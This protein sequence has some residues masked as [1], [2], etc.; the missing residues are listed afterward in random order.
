MR[1]SG[2]Y[3]AL[4]I[5]GWS[6]YFILI[7][8][9]LTLADVLDTKQVLSFFFLSVYFLFTTHFLRLIVLKRQWLNV[10]VSNFIGKLTFTILVFS[11]FNFGFQ[12]LLSFIFGLLEFSRDFQP[13]FILAN[14][15]EAVALYFLWTIIYFLYHYVDNYNKNLKY[16]AK[17]NEIE[18]NHLKSQLNP[19]F[20]FNALNSIRALVHENPEK[21]KKAIT[22]LS[23]ILRNSLAVDKKRL[24]SF[25]DELATVK[26]Y[27]E[28]E[29]IRFEER[30]NVKYNIDPSAFQFEVPPMMI[31]TLVENGI[32][33]GIS[34]LKN[35][36][37]LSLNA[38]VEDGQLKIEIRNSG[39]YVNGK[40]VKKRSGF[41]IDN[42][43]QRLKILYGNNASFDIKNDNEEGVL[44]SLRLPQLT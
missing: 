5:G 13:F 22:Q 2:L 27:L 34:T 11:L 16:E 17:I 15:L 26:D 37:T 18:L 28:L 43:K 21:S 10:H 8:F 44:T 30:L 9:F 12:I 25:S 6:V 42:T 19:H 1:R 24:T 40:K 20:I 36:G 14:I 31:Q 38:T 39:K 4:Q 35:G 33:H 3:W 29:S 41:G 32:K 23:N 7:I